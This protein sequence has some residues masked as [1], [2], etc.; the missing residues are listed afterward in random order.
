MAR[1]KILYIT[2]L[3]LAIT[4]VA[5]ITLISKSNNIL[6]NLGITI[7]LEQHRRTL[8]LETIDRTKSCLDF[9]IQ[10]DASNYTVFR[11]FL[12]ERCGTSDPKA[13]QKTINHLQA[14]L[15]VNQRP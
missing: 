2:L 1:R 9:S 14:T 8:M 5:V 10:H 7:A 4:V 13:L 6:L 11:H 12:R 15:Q 3:I